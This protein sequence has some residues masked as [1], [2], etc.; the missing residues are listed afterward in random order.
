M[1]AKR[2]KLKYS[3]VSQTL[4]ILETSRDRTV[5]SIAVNIAEDDTNTIKHKAQREKLP[6]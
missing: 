3:Q 4:Q 2:Y 5:Q 1:Q 6:S